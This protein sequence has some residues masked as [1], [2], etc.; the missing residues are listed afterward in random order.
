MEALKITA[1]IINRVISKSVPNT[2][3]ELW[4]SKKPSINYFHVSV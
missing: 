3:Y 1:H 2:P 4:T